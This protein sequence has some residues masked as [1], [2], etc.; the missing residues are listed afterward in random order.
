[1][2]RAL[3]VGR[4]QPFHLGH[5]EVCRRILAENDA[6]V[7]A[8]GSA[9]SSHS[10]V[11][12]FTAG[13]RYAMIEAA[14]AEADLDRV[15]II[16]LPDVN[17]NAIWVSHVRSLVPPFEVL[18]SNNPLPRRLFAE[19]GFE[20]RDAPFHE[21]ARYEG[22]RIR[23]A[24]VADGD[25]EHDVPRGVARVIREIGGVDRVQMLARSDAVDKP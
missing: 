23:H 5:L 2:R 21:R 19:A 7:I 15:A 8:I 9:E 11:N 20:V 6:L 25:W 18:Y 3:F 1:M 12:P 22:T 4:F 14:C 24:M 17:R 13:E 16:P 10:L